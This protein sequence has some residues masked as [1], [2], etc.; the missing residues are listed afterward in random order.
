MD[1]AGKF[2]RVFKNALRKDTLMVDGGAY[3]IIRFK[4]TNPGE[5]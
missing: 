1:A 3:S 4:A 5:Y 2:P